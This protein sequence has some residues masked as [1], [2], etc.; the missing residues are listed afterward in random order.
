MYIV[1]GNDDVFALNAKTGEFLWERWSGIDQKITSVCCGWDNP[2]RQR[3]R[4]E[5]NQPAQ[6]Q[7]GARDKAWFALDSPLEGDR[8][9]LSVPRQRTSVYRLI[10]SVACEG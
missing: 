4:R 8:F 1:T 7:V 10:R 2:P 9:E 6:R 5:A 3:A